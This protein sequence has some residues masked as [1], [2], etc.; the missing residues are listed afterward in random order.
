MDA[1]SVFIVGI[2]GPVGSGKTTLLK[3][4]CTE[5]R[6]ELS[7]GVITNDIHTRIDADYLASSEILARERIHSVITGQ[8]KKGIFRY[9]PSRNQTVIDQLLE[10]IDDLELI[11]V[12]GV[13]DRQDARFKPSMVDVFIYV[14]DAN[15]GTSIPLKGGPGIL[16]SDLL[17]VNKID[18]L[19]NRRGP[20]GELSLNIQSVKEYGSYIFASLDTGYAVD[21][22]VDFVLTQCKKQ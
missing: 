1:Q 7:I 5:L 19:H 2:G 8:T 22:I 10:E 21:R 3:C 9:S 16:T 20:V 14:I 18:L 11:L 12:E 17:V 15:S 13:G 6:D 4:L